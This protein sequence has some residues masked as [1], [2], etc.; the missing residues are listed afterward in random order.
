MHFMDLRGVQPSQVGLHEAREV[1]A[2]MFSQRRLHTTAQQ[3]LWNLHQ[4]VGRLG[5]HKSPILTQKQMSAPLCEI[6]WQEICSRKSIVFLLLEIKCLEIEVREV[7][8]SQRWQKRQ[9]APELPCR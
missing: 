3:R 9:H 4:A 1:D 8:S 2:N 6:A 5:K 7:F